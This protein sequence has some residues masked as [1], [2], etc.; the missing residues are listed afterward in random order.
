MTRFDSKYRLIQV[1]LPAAI[2]HVAPMTGS[3]SSQPGNAEFLSINLHPKIIKSTPKS[4]IHWLVNDVS[5]VF[6]S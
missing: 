5:D 3:N 6:F 2:R 1:F 4:D